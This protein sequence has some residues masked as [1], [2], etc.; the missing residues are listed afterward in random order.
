M[1]GKGGD[2]VAQYFALHKVFEDQELPN[3]YRMSRH[4]SAGVPGAFEPVIAVRK[5]LDKGYGKALLAA[6]VSLQGEA[7]AR[8]PGN[9]LEDTFFLKEGSIRTIVTQTIPDL[10]GA[11]KA[12]EYLPEHYRGWIRPAARQASADKKST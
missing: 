11:D 10:V 2:P 1:A 12:A 4:P 8:A 7:R 9:G 6:T 5:P 3:R